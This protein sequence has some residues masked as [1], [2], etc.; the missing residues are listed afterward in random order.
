[1]EDRHDFIIKCILVIKHSPVLARRV[2]AGYRLLVNYI[3]L[4]LLNSIEVGYL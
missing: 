1:M 4:F 2:M 3:W